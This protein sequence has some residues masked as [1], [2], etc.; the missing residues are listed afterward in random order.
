M[1]IGGSHTRA[2]LV[3][4]GNGNQAGDR[5]LTEHS[6]AL[7][8]KQAL[9]TLIRSLLATTNQTLRAA[10][11]SCAGPVQSG[12]VSM[13]NWP[14][15]DTI[16]LDDLAGI[17]LP[18][19]A[20]TLINDMEAAAR[21]LIG[22]K[23]GRIKL[24]VSTLYTPANTGPLHFNNAILIIP[25]TG[26][27]VAGIIL[28]DGTAPAH[29]S[30]ELQHTAAAGLD[31]KYNDLLAAL[32][33]RLNKD[34]LS[35]EDLVSGKGLESLHASIQERTHP[36]AGMILSAAVIASR[37]VTAADPTCVEALACYYHTA[38]ALAQ[39]MALAYQPFAGIYLGG[40]TTGKNLDFIHRSSFVN[41]LQDNDLRHDLL[42]SFPVYL[43]PAYM[44][45][46]GAQYL[47]SDRYQ[48]MVH[49]ATHTHP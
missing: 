10:V 40:E 35:W 31:R 28:G 42:R 37:A 20:T 15:Q 12:A 13:T 18:R 17:G 22:Y 45:L 11:L 3:R 33:R 23:L 43:V 26:V 21:C 24:E 39:V 30:C 25:G 47:A 29:V 48:P 6:V 19:P 9:F 44:N 27:G 38:G 4:V 5:V 46:L 41:R 36:D 14:K 1:D 7:T 16:S 2:R 32:M 34:Y 8:D 49:P